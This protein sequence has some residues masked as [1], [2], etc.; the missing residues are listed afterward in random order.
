[1]SNLLLINNLNNSY[2]IKTTAGWFSVNRLNDKSK[3]LLPED[4]LDHLLLWRI[5]SFKVSPFKT[6][7]ETG[8]LSGGEVMM[9]KITAGPKMKRG[10]S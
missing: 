1:M 6:D 4:S 3:N 2:F 9:E 7:K 8:C 10:A 5:A